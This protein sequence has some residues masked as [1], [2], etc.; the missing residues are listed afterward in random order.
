MPPPVTKKASTVC[1]NPDDYNGNATLPGAPTQ[2]CDSVMHQLN[3]I[4]AFR[5]RDCD[6]KRGYNSKTGQDCTGGE[7]CQ[8]DIVGLYMQGFMVNCCKDGMHACRTKEN[9]PGAYVCV[10][11]CA[12][13]FKFHRPGYRGMPRGGVR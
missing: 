9:N 2:T 10:C 1:K 12:C 3:N 8:L 11:V 6:P 4:P 7:G 13:V 5:E